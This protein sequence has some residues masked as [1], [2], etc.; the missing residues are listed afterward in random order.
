LLDVADDVTGPLICDGKGFV[1]KVCDTRNYFTHYSPELRN[2][3]LRGMEMH[4]ANE[5]L[6]YIIKRCLLTEFGFSAEDCV[7]LFRRNRRYRFAVA[8]LAGESKT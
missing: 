3:L 8:R 7:R 4:R 2:K 5:A 1:Q 6:S